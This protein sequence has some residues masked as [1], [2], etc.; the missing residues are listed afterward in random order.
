M[1]WLR[2]IGGHAQT[3]AD[4][5]RVSFTEAPSCGHGDDP[6]SWTRRLLGDEPV[7]DIFPPNDAQFATDEHARLKHLFPEARI[8]EPPR[9][10]DEP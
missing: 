3:Y 10:S 8:Y 4:E 2:S 1:E 7:L 5:D 9:K 6:L